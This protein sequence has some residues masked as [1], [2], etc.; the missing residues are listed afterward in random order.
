MSV[1]CPQLQEFCYSSDEFPPSAEALWSLANG[2]TH[3]QHLSL[4]PVVGRCVQLREGKEQMHR[5]LGIHA[6]KSRVKSD[7]ETEKLSRNKSTN[8]LTVICF[9]LC[10]PH[11]DW[12]TD[13][14]IL[15]I[16]RGWPSLRS[17]CVGGK[18]IT[19]NGLAAVGESQ[20]V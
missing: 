4:P 5:P 19:T 16:A 6:H 3:I 8:D 15:T 1:H 9:T 17:L 7:K 10:S 13:N 20:L 2:C 12:F 11:V 18:V 14:C